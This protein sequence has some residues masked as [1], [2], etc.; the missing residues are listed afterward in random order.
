MVIILANFL[1]FICFYLC[2]GSVFLWLILLRLL[3]SSGHFCW[4]FLFL[5]CAAITK[6]GCGYPHVVLV[7]FFSLVLGGDGQI[8]L[9]VLKECDW[10]H[11]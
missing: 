6:S 5:P 7:L 10:K 3:L 11:F 2:P 8:H 9:A 4:F 1:L